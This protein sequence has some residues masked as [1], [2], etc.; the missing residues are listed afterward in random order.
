MNNLV[1]KSKQK[2]KI[3]SY[4]EDMRLSIVIGLIIWQC[5]KRISVSS[6]E[7]KLQGA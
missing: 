2:L 3:Q 5:G 1:A 4:D 7:R 6:D